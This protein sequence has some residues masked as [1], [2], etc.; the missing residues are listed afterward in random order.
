MKIDTCHDIHYTTPVARWDEGLPCGNGLLGLLVWGD[1][2]PLNLSVDRLDLWDN[3]EDPATKRK[4]FNWKKLK[5]FFKRGD[6]KSIID[7]FE[8]NTDFTV[9]PTK[10]PCGRITLDFGKGS[11]GMFDSRLCLTQAITTTRIGQATI[12][13]YV[14]AEQPLVVVRA[15]HANPRVEF[16]S[17]FDRLRR[18]PN[19]GPWDPAR[20]GYP[21][22]ERGRYPDGGNYVLQRCAEGVSYV[23]AWYSL[24]VQGEW[25][26]YLTI[27]RADQGQDPRPDALAILEAAM[28]TGVRLLERSHLAWWRNY[29]RKGR[30]SLPDT[31][32]ERLWYLE[33]YKLGATARENTPPISLQ[34][35]WT[36]DEQGLPPWRGD[37]HHD[38]NTQLSYWPVHTAGRREQSLGFAKWLLKWL[39]SFQAFARDFYDAPGAN[40]P[41]SM[42]LSGA[43][44]RGWSQYVYSRTNAAWLIQHLWWHY[45]YTMDREFLKSTAYPFMREITR[46]IVSQLDVDAKG[47]YHLHYS[48]SPEFDPAPSRPGTYARDSTYDLALVRY[49]LETTSAAA[50]IL[51]T[52][53]NEA[54]GWRRIRARLPAYAISPERRNLAPNEHGLAIWPGQGLTE[55]HRHLSHLMPIFPLGDLNVEGTDED[56][57]LIRNCLCELELQGTGLW[58][59]YS[60]S[61]LACLAARIREPR[62]VLWA[63][64][65]YLDAFVSPNSFHLNGDYKNLGAGRI[66]YRPF[67]LEGNFAAAHAVNE[68]L[69]Q[70][71]GNRIRLFP[72]VPADWRDAA[73]TDL[74]AE[75]A[76]VI[77]AAKR[78]GEFY[79]AEIHSEKGVSVCLEHPDARR[80]V[81]V[82]QAGGGFSRVFPPC[83]D[84]Q[85]PTAPG[86]RYIVTPGMD[87]TASRCLTMKTRRMAW[88]E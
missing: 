45:R 86:A 65:Q 10:L 77:S 43:I 27:Q 80:I 84:I 2:R 67:T 88:R 34:G 11:P 75:G 42:G 85:F 79:R 87:L 56:R 31:R 73:F 9:Y 15:C 63:L 74:R 49:A 23:V 59:G 36:A 26:L 72:A 38:L 19:P 16:L 32:I 69:L 58:C 46:F 70:S 1:G 7:I 71:W 76:F 20:L 68:M 13:A 82:R 61:W 57:Q 12:T 22:S 52:D 30:I 29:W 41:C 37:Y 60:F 50:E 78:R 6:R 24:T 21:P 64:N 40:V 28:T 48:S 53:G 33:M 35:V 66:H 55:S 3:R 39:P 47:I 81:Q 25:I 62:R 51:R 8:H 83:K 44:V 4:E 14:H 17:P 54:R 5:E 18:N